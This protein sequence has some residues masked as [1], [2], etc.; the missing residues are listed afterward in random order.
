MK[1]WVE[2]KEENTGLKV[3]EIADEP[4]KKGGKKHTLDLMFENF[5]SLQKVLTNVAEDLSQLN[6]K[7]EN[8]LNLFE[9]SAKS[10]SEKRPE[11]EKAKEIANKIDEI[12]SQ[13][14]IIAKGVMLL[15]QSVRKE[16]EEYPFKPKP[17]PEL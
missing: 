5:I 16:N 6:A 1:K 13:N 17:L 11:D 4:D 8:L 2:E 3:K 7:L 14:R 9:E 15:E 10:F 12:S